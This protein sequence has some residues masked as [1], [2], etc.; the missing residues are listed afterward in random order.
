MK[1]NHLEHVEDY[2]LTGHFIQGIDVIASVAEAITGRVSKHL[3]IST[4]YDGAPA[5][6]FGINPDNGK[7][8]IGTKSVFNKRIPKIA[9][10]EEDIH[11]LY[12]DSPGL[13]QKLCTAFDLL[14]Y[15]Y[16][17]LETVPNGVYQGDLMFTKD[18]LLSDDRTVYFTPNT[19]TY[20]SNKNCDL[21]KVIAEAPMGIVLHTQYHGDVL[22]EMVAKPVDRYEFVDMNSQVMFIDPAVDINDYILTPL[23]YNTILDSIGFCEK[24]HD[25]ITDRSIYIRHG[26][27]LKMFMNHCIKIGESNPGVPMYTTFLV[28]RKQDALAKESVDKMGIFQDIFV[29]YR[30]MWYMKLILIQEMSANPAFFTEVNGTPTKGEGFV[31]SYHGVLCK[32]VD[33]REF[34]RL[35]FANKRFAST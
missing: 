26:D 25:T 18:S 15:E 7:F 3:K 32:F 20:R 6:V 34:S 33:R 31:I 23:Q 22:A 1:L 17:G 27:M 19:I 11:A 21:G 30:H 4:K 28:N 14:A 8:F 9:Y 10:S 2:L 16:F 5:I 12:G 13:A 35:N 29:M 24:T